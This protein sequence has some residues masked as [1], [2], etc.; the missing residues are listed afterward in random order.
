MFDKKVVVV[1]GGASGI[2]LATTKLFASLGALVVV[3]DRNGEGAEQAAAEIGPTATPAT[4]DVSNSTQVQKLVND[5][6]NRF[7]RIDVLVNN[8]G[9]GF[10]GTVENTEEDD[11]DRLIAVNLKGMFLCS[12]Y[13][14]PVMAANGGGVIVNTGSYTAQVAIGNRAAY[15]ASKG[16]VVSLSRAMAIDHAHQGVRVNCVAPGTIWSP[17]FDQMA[18]QSDDP[19]AMRNELDSRAVVGRTGR[20]DEVAEAIVWLASDKSQFAVGSTLTIDGGS[21]IW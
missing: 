11:W 7:G 1:T 16:G 6:K 5:T 2:G 12:K 14:I 10:A 4:V 20:P 17:Y 18:A 15:I 19:E 21:S 8:A 3:A 13:V 9:F